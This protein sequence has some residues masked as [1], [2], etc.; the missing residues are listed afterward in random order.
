VNRK[1]IETPLV[2]T[3][4]MKLQQICGGFLIDEDGEP[5]DVGEEKLRLLSQALDRVPTGK[6]VVVVCRFL[7]EIDRIRQV[8]RARKYRVTVIR[9][10]VEFYANA[11]ITATAI[12]VQI[13]SGVSID[14]AVASYMIY[15]SWDHSYINNEQSR[16]RVLSYTSPRVTYYYLVMKET[17]DELILQ[18]VI[19]KK[20]LATLVCDHY[21]RRSK[22]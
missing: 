2:I 7:H 20:N 22:R 18:T 19:R 14:L 9:G 12:I 15:Y 16:F 11:P 17:I 4:S 8:L 1:R 21:R 5:H 3:L 13:Q 10:G 6:R